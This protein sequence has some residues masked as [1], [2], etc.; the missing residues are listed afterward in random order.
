M[1]KRSIIKPAAVTLAVIASIGSASGNPAAARELCVG[2]PGCFATVKAAVNAAHEGDTIRIGA[3]TFDG[4]F[5]IDKSLS[6]VGVSA[7]VV[8]IEGGGPV[9]TIAAGLAP[10]PPTV[11]IMRVTI[12]GGRNVS[13]PLPF[14][15]LGGGV[16]IPGRP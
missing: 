10:D 4:G 9:I 15:A 5:T 8:R 11:S 7:A 12:S 16:W 3:G 1:M 6:L 14:A 2:G 13:V